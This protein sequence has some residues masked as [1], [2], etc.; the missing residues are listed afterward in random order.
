MDLT[1]QRYRGD[2]ERAIRDG[3]LRCFVGVQMEVYKSSSVPLQMKYFQNYW[4]GPSRE[5]RRGCRY[6]PGPARRF[7]FVFLVSN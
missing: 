2:A 4:I 7:Y 1:C 5:R 3:L 6:Y